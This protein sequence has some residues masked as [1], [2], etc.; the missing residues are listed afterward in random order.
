MREYESIFVLDPEVGEE[1]VDQEVDKI[2]S[3]IAAGEGEV[4]EVQKWG[5]RKL[6][7]EIRKRKEGIYTLV[8]FTGTTKELDE[9]NRQYRLNE[10]LLRHLTVVYEGPMPGEGEMTEG[11]EM[12]ADSEGNPPR[13]AAS[14]ARR[15]RDDDDS[16]DDN[17]D[18]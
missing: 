12:D 6:A 16:D 11:G 18:D 17:N 8:R 3:V 14:H 15:D 4:T 5:R 13:S 7:Y 9:L 10:D 1:R 2:R